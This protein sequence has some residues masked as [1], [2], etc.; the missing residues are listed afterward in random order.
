MPMRQ[1][2][3]GPV[4]AIDQGDAQRPILRRQAADLDVGAF[5]DRK[6]HHVGR[7]VGLDQFLLAAC[8]S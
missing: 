1:P 6:N 3:F 8:R 2:P 5:D 4:A 7:A